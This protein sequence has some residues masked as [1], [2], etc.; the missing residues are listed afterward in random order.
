[1]VAPNCLAACAIAGAACAGSA[2]PVAGGVQRAQPGPREARQHPDGL[3]AREH[4]AVQLHRLADLLQ[5]GLPLRQLLLRAA[6][7][8]DTAAAEA[9][10]GADHVVHLRPQPQRLDRQRQLPRVAAH[11]AAPAPVAAGLF[12]GDLPLF[13][14]H[15]GHAFAG[16]KER[17]ADANDAATDDDD[18]R[19]LRGFRIAWNDVDRGAMLVLVASVKG[20]RTNSILTLA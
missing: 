15:D 12:G 2:L 14:Q 8:N 19:Y 20:L 17:R 5:P 1:M 6:E 9:G 3:V 7:I 16:Q 13:A 10:F 18:A 4:A 11:L